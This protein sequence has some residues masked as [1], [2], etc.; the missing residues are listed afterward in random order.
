MTVLITGGT[1]LIGAEVARMLLDQGEER[2]YVFDINSSTKLL[3]NEASEVE[4][5]RA[6]WVT[7]VMF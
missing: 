6:I 1:G 3:D 2:I 5:V 7:S 4:I